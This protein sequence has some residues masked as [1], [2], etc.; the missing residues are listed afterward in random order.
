MSNVS[1]EQCIKCGT[2]TIWFTCNHRFDKFFAFL[3]KG[4]RGIKILVNY[5]WEIEKK[6]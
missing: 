4:L 1:R 2:F 5:I 6:I 3:L